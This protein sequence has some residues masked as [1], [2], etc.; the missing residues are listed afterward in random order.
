MYFLAYFTLQGTLIKLNTL[1]KVEDH[2]NHVR[3]IYL[4]TVLYMGESQKYARI[5]IC[6]TLINRH[7]LFYHQVQ[8]MTLNARQ[9]I[10]DNLMADDIYCYHAVLFK[11]NICIC[12]ER[13]LYN[14]TPLLQIFILVPAL[15]IVVTTSKG[16]SRGSE[17][18]SWNLKSPTWWGGGI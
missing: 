13:S 11:V 9:F 4:K 6:C 12:E 7:R 15:C 5:L 18:K 10:R 1:R 8:K 14:W 17:K 16:R 3:W 2:E